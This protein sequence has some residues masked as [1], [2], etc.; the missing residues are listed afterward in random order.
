MKRVGIE[1]NCFHLQD[2]TRCKLLAGFSRTLPSL[3]DIIS[4]RRETLLGRNADR[5]CAHTDVT[6]V[7]YSVGTSFSERKMREM[8]VTF[9]TNGE[10]RCLMT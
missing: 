1:M 10:E 5:K 8:G 2:V 4:V 9:F 3:N 6:A 7:N